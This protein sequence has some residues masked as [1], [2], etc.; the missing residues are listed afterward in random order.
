MRRL[1]TDGSAEL[2]PLQLDSIS[3]AVFED[4]P[5]QDSSPSPE[6]NNTVLH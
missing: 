3:D 2:V 4:Q 1:D 6:G 5:Y